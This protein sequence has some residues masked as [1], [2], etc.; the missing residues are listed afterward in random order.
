MQCQD[1]V[2]LFSD[3]LDDN[4]TDDQENLVKDHLRRCKGC[5]HNFKLVET[6]L[7]LL[8]KYPKIEVSP[9]FET[10]LWSRIRASEPNAWQKFLAFFQSPTSANPYLSPAFA[11]A[12]ALVIIAGTGF[13]MRGY[14]QSSPPLAPQTLA[15]SPLPPHKPVSPCQ[16][17]P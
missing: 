8:P 6:T 4:L 10:R 9:G 13:V 3:Y 17:I 5:E 2:A 14:L 12:T 16:T 7:Q 1:V 15:E 11:L